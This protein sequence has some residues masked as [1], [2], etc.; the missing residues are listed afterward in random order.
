MSI[1]GPIYETESPKIASADDRCWRR[2]IYETDRSC[3]GVASLVVMGWT[4]PRRHRFAKMALEAIKG[5]ETVAELASKHELH[6]TQIAASSPL[7]A[8]V[9]P[10]CAT[11]R[12]YVNSSFGQR[13]QFF[14]GLDLRRACAL[15]KLS[16]ATV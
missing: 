7:P 3:L 8:A 12:R 14:V 16:R 11:R 2:S 13:L 6:P 4:P 15:A 1:Y 5:H 9:R 10:P